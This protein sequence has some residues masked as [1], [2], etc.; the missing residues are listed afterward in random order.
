MEVLIWIVLIVGGFFAYI[1]WP[2]Q[3]LKKRVEIINTSLAK[4]LDVTNY[5][6]EKKPKQ[7]LSAIKSLDINMDKIENTISVLGG[8]VCNLCWIANDLVD[9][10]EIEKAN[11]NPNNLAGETT[12]CFIEDGFIILEYPFHSVRIG[13]HF[14]NHL[15]DTQEFKNEIDKLEYSARKLGFDDIVDITYSDEKVT[16]NSGTSSVSGEMAGTTTS[17]TFHMSDGDFG[18]SFGKG[19]FAG[20]ISMDGTQGGVSKD[21]TAEATL[22][23]F[24]ANQGEPIELNLIPIDM[25]DYDTIENLQT[26]P[27]EFIRHAHKDEEEVRKLQN[28]FQAMTAHMKRKDTLEEKKRELENKDRFSNSDLSDDA[29]KIFLTK[30][31]SLEKNDVLNKYVVN[32]RLFDTVED[33]LAHADELYRNNK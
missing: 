16:V 33:A 28:L 32:E 23:I 10:G 9:E 25:S 26:M 21:L 3:E 7:F 15:K 5:F 30:K 24:T 31:F 11:N 13:E 4:E 22:K 19:T 12:V 2:D 17:S 6:I 18:A 8:E 20:D 27:D 1:F 14:D 29:Y